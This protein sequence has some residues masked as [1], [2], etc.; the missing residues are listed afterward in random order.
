MKILVLFIIILQKII[1]RVSM[2]CIRSLFKKCGKNVFF[3]SKDR[4]SY[5]TISLGNDVF[6]GPGAHFSTISSIEIGNKVMFGP[7]VTIIGGDHNTKKIGKYM[8]DVEEKD[9]SNDLPVVIKDD[10][11]IAAGVIILKGVV[12]GEGSIIAAGSV[13]NKD[14][15]PY[16]IV[17]GVPAKVLKFRFDKTELEEH[18]K[19]LEKIRNMSY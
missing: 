4:F 12:I 3:T 13:V 5:S 16:S 11:W 1:G 9:P 10:V 14:V 18:K 6:I 2:Y 17:G 7:N 8:F 15:P 19:K